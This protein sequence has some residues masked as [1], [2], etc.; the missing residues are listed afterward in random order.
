MVLDPRFLISCALSLEELGS[1]SRAWGDTLLAGAACRT[2]HRAPWPTA[3]ADGGMV[4]VMAPLPVPSDPSATTVNSTMG[5][6]GIAR[7]PPPSHI[8]NIGFS[9]KTY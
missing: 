2:G 9:S 3:K 6:Q 8:K 4:R 5:E 7:A 1:D